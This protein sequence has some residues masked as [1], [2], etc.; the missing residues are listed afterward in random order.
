MTKINCA[1]KNYMTMVILIKFR[2]KTGYR[3]VMCTIKRYVKKL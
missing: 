2:Q 3:F 1:F